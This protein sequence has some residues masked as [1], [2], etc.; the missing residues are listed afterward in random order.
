MSSRNI[1]QRTIGMPESRSRQIANAAAY[2]NITG[3]EFIQSA[4]T[5]ALLS[6]AEADKVFAHVLARSAGI[7]WQDLASATHGDV[8]AKLAP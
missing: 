7:D 5:A 3:E 4:I 2:L 8:L 1:R 6:L